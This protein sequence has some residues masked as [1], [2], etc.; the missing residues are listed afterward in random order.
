[1]E[2]RHERFDSRSRTLRP[3]INVQC[4]LDGR[5]GRWSAQFYGRYGYRGS[6]F[7]KHRRWILHGYRCPLSR[8]TSRTRY[9]V[10]S[11]Y[12][13][14]SINTYIVSNTIIWMFLYRWLCGTAKSGNEYQTGCFLQLIIF[15]ALSVRYDRRNIIRK[16]SRRHQLGIRGCRWNIYIYSISR[17]GW[18]H[19]TRVI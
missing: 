11:I 14:I 18:Y 2:S 7:S 12:D 3:R 6:F 1:M 10:S 5:N 15:S 19:S 8:V 9:C 16:Y 17:H 4:G 13:G